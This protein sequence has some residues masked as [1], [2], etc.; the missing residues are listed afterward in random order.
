MS[1]LTEPQ[2]KK[3]SLHVAK[4]LGTRLVF[5]HFFEY[6]ASSQRGRATQFVGFNSSS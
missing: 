6:N 3:V 5:S 1:L 4:S 2:D